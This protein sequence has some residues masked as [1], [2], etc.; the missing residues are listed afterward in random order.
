MTDQT[1]SGHLLKLFRA[2]EAQ[3]LINAARGIPGQDLHAAIAQA[4]I[5]VLEAGFLL[6]DLDDFRFCP[7]YTGT[8]WLENMDELDS[9]EHKACL[10][11]MEIDENEFR[12]DVMKNI[13][14]LT[15]PSPLGALTRARARQLRG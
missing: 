3:A 13:T 7:G 1:D 8:Y 14:R 4:F 6:S 11:E 10:A 15:L 9:A 2:A 12:A 5:A